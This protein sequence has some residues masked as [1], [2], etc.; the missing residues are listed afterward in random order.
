MLLSTTLLRDHQYSQQGPTRYNRQT[1]A[2]TWQY[3]FYFLKKEKRKGGWV[4][5]VVKYKG[6]RKPLASATS[7]RSHR[8]AI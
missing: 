1:L 4:E 6:A 5:L 2:S 3:F 7:R 8:F